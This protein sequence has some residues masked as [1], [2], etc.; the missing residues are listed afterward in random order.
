MQS[1]HTKNNI[2]N[3][4]VTIPNIISFIRILLIP[5]F[6]I[7][8]IKNMNTEA[9]L[10]F[11]ISSISDG[12]DGF[13]ARRFNQVSELGKILD[14]I[15]DRGLLLVG[16]IVLCYISRLPLWILI[17]VLVRDLT[18]IFG[19]LYMIKKYKFKPKVIMLGKIATTFFYIGFALLVLNFPFAQG[20]N[21]FDISSSILPG[22]GHERYLLGI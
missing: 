12:L 6:V 18:F 21:L 10:V 14:P 13:I 4:I 16:S 8:L 7:L 22:F 3:R 17:L 2:E 5:V 19:G 9:F 20:F 11:V 15:A 1:K